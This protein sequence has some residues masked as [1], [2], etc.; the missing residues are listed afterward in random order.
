M[1][2]N[3][4]VFK[5]DDTPEIIKMKLVFLAIIICT[6]IV[7]YLISG[8]LTVAIPIGMLTAI[9]WLLTTIWREQKAIKKARA[10]EAQNIQ[11]QGDM[12]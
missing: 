8:L 1:Y 10:A 5:E 12:Q 9:T 6:S 3:Q 4:Q 2:K 7:V 11:Q